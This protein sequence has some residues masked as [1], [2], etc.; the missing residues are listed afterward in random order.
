MNA[1]TP[2]SS[3]QKTPS[4]IKVDRAVGALVWL[5]TL[6]LFELARR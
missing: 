3:T 6:M 4:R 5:I 2:R 1:L